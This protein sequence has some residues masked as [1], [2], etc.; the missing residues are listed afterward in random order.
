MLPE[1]FNKVKNKDLTPICFAVLI[2]DEYGLPGVSPRCYMIDGALK[3][4]PQ[5]S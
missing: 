4:H 5:W 2:I 1:N 3:F